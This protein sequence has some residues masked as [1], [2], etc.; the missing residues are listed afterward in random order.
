MYKMQLG[1]SEGEVIPSGAY[2]EQ[3]NNGEVRRLFRMLEGECGV[4]RID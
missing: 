3:L 1:Q 4:Y 2:S